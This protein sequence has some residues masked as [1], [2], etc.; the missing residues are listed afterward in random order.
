MGEETRH[1]LWLKR[2]NTW[3]AILGGSVASVAG[4]YNF[5]P[6]F[7]PAAPGDISAVVRAEGGSPVSRAHVELL[8]SQNVLLSASETDRNGRYVKKDLEPGSYILK[9]SRGGFEPEVAT[10]NVA[11]KK[12]TDLDLVLRSRSRT[13]APASPQP[14]ASP[15]PQGS[16][17][18][19][20]LE[21]TGAS[22]IKS[23]GKSGK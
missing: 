10:L 18:R 21:E 5:Y 2:V 23:F 3:I 20:A 11:S 19:S 22:W 17:L 15:Q 8:T 9:V 16:A 6:N 12:T 14:V 13:Q 1:D 4:A 7:F